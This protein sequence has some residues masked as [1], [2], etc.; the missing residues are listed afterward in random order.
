VGGIPYLL[1]HEQD[2]LL[3][4]SDDPKAMAAAVKRLLEDPGL[5]KKLSE[6]AR[7]KAEGFD[8]SAIFPQ[9]ERVLKGALMP[10]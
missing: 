3:V 4:P 7:R 9:W 1:D 2:A 6:G 10:E 5:A 8:W